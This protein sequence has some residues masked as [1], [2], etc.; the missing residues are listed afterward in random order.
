MRNEPPERSHLGDAVA[1]SRE[2]ADLLIAPETGTV[3]MTE[4]EQLDRMVEAGRRAARTA[5]AGAPDLVST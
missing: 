5:L 1:A 2:H 3:G 4:F